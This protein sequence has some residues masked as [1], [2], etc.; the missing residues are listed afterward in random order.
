MGRGIPGSSDLDDAVNRTDCH[1]CCLFMVAYAVAADAF[2]YNIEVVTR[3]DSR[4]RTFRF[5][6]SAV[7][8]FIGNTV[9]HDVSCG[10]RSSDRECVVYG[11]IR[12]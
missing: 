11:K 5:T 7:G 2:V 3:S 9:C 8:A 1:T 4:N 6:G 12:Q 10:L